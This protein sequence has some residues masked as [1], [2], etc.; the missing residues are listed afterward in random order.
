MLKGLALEI[1]PFWYEYSADQKNHLTSLSPLEHEEE[2][3][4]AGF[5]HEAD[6]L[7]APQAKVDVSE[8]KVHG[9]RLKQRQGPRVKREGGCTAGH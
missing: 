4:A 7:T 1:D 5:E 9:K 8:S 2:G 3:Q 6:A